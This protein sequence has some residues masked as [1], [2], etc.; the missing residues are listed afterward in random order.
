MKQQRILTKK[1]K[2]RLEKTDALSV[3][4]KRKGYLKAERTVSVA[5]ANAMSVVLALP[6]IIVF[7][8]WFVV[9]N[10][11]SFVPTAGWFFGLAA[12]TL[13]LA[14]VH[15]LV[16]GTAWALAVP[17]GFGSV[18]FGFIRETLTPYCCCAEPMTKGQY[19]AGSFAPCFFLGILPAAA[20]CLCGSVFLLVL[21]LI[22]IVS[23]GGDLLCGLKLIAYKSRRKHLLYLD[24]PTECGFI[25]FEK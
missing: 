16:H 3:T 4:L 11:F 8:A 5:A 23:A 19:L 7:T 6:Y 1:E 17:G 13:L 14:P 24:H 18:E 2:A 21:A 22:M 10:G 12:A 9:R 25:V 15:E 20:A